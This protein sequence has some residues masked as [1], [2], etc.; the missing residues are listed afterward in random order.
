MNLP[1][2]LPAG[3]A[4]K[5][6]KPSRGKPPSTFGTFTSISIVTKRFVSSWKL[7]HEQ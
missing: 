3:K 2:A 1:T 7:K 6:Q 5:A 4:Q